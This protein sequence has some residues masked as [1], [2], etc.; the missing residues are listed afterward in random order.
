MDS[1]LCPCM[2]PVL[3]RLEEQYFSLCETGIMPLQTQTYAELMFTPPKSQQSVVPTCVSEKLNLTHT[4]PCF[5]FISLSMTVMLWRLYVQ[6]SIFLVVCSTDNNSSWMLQVL[7]HHSH[8]YDF[9]V[10]H[11]GD[12]WD[13]SCWLQAETGGSDPGSEFN[14]TGIFR[15]EQNMNF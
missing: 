5:C 10:G 6:R 15:W 7:V 8:R 3:S 2:P 12:V 1:G 9:F 4:K 11:V 14:L 13:D